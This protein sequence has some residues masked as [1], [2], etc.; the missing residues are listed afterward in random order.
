MP[1]GATTGQVLRT[2]HAGRRGAGGGRNC[3][4]FC[5]RDFD[6]AEMPNVHVGPLIVARR[7]PAE[8]TAR[9]KLAP[10]E[11]PRT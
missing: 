1:L 7:R 11:T 5:R 6:L 2:G 10:S 4:G 9:L 3:A 8:R